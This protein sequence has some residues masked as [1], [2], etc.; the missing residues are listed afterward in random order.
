MDDLTPVVPLAASVLFNLSLISI[1]VVA[2]TATTKK[3]GYTPHAIYKWS[4]KFTCLIHS[5]IMSTVGFATVSLEDWDKKNLVHGESTWV[6]G[7]VAW[8]LGYLCVDLCMMCYEKIKHNRWAGVCIVSH[9][10]GFIIVLPLYYQCSCMSYFIGVFFTINLSTA[11]WQLRYILVKSGNAATWAFR[12][13]TI[14]FLLA[15]FFCRFLG[16]PF[17]FWKL[18]CH[19]NLSW[20]EAPFQLPRKCLVGSAL[21]MGFNF[22]W[23]SYLFRNIVVFNKARKVKKIS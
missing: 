1:S 9:H 17:M 6:Y 14:G 5:I 16:I 4:S 11:F 22:Y 20:Y 8:E 21:V 3:S 15:Y 23:F 12:L 7:G 10:V 2:R 19:Q 18:A 13:A